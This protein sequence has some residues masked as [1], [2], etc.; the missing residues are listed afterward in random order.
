MKRILNKVVNSATGLNKAGVIYYDGSGWYG[1]VYIN[2][3]YFHWSGSEKNEEVPESL[4]DWFAEYG[5]RHVRLLL[6]SE[7]QLLDFVLPD[8]MS[9]EELSL[10]LSN[11]LSIITG[12]DSAGI[13]CT[14]VSSLTLGMK[15]NYLLVGSFAKSKIEEYRRAVESKGFVF[16]GVG[17]LELSYFAYCSNKYNINY[18]SFIVFGESH[19]FVLPGNQ[20]LKKVGPMSLPG[21]SRNAELDYSSWLMKVE[22]RLRSLNEC[23][24]VYTLAFPEEVNAVKMGLEEVLADDS[25]CF[26]DYADIREKLAHLSV[27]TKVN[28]FSSPLNIVND[29]MPRKLFSNAFILFPV[30][31]I[32]SVPFAFWGAAEINFAKKVKVIDNEI[33]IHIPPFFLSLG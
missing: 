10:L 28:S 20:H 3:E 16:G 15:D 22:K 1:V 31:L 17:C 2:H 13:I 9:Y 11:E 23:S 5:V 32:L 19:S 8:K 12:E 21:G 6:S 14:A 33:G 18:D 7:L 24:S 29:K 25:V 27:H 26:V 30:L 4:L